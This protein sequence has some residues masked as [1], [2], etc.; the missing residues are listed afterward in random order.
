MADVS[1]QAEDLGRRANDNKW[2]D[3]GIR[4]GMICY[5]VVYLLIAWLA[6]QLA[7]GSQQSNASS[8]GALQLLGQ[9]S[10][11][12]LLLWLVAI[13]L[14]VLVIWRA[15]EALVGHQEYDGGKRT[16]RRL[17][18]AGKA[19]IY[20]YVAYLA[21]RYAIGAGSSG[22][23]DSTTAKLMDQPFGRFLVGLVGVAIAAYGV[24]QIRRGW[25]E[26]FMENLDAR[27]SAGDAGKA[28]RLDRQG[29]LHRQGHRLHPRRRPVRG[30]GLHPS[31]EEVGQPRP[32]TAQPSR[33]PVRPGAA[34]RHRRGNRLLR[35]VLLRAC[36]PPVPVTGSA[37]FASTGPSLPDGWGSR[38]PDQDDVPVLVA[39]R[40][41]DRA[42]FTGERRVDEAAI[43]SEVVGPASWTRRQVVVTDADDRVRG[44][45]SVQDRAAGRT[46][47]GL[48]LDRDAPD[49]DAVAAGLYAWADHEGRAIAHLRGL[50][51]TR[52]DAS[53]FAADHRQ[54]GWLEDAGYACRRRWLHM[55]R[56]V[57]ATEMMPPLREGVT[58]RRV[59]RHENGVP[60]AS[61]LQ[62]VH[63][64]LEESFQ[65]HFNSYRE[66]FPEFVQRLRED[67]GHR[68]DHWWLAWV[69][70]VP[71]GAIICSV[72]AAD[73]TGAEGTYVDYIGVNRVARGRGV[74]KGLL[75][76]VLSDAAERGRD[77]VSLEV[78]ADS[79]TR[80]D[81]LYVSMGWATDYVTESWFRD[82]EAA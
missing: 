41:A 60:L 56:P 48:W 67:P 78:D 64:M 22:S 50:E 63:R 77:R 36:P 29:G 61:D 51:R 11:G 53:P 57:D 74:A 47:V 46:V 69:D 35:V 28:Y 45:I 54:R 26:K 7:L 68:W 40:L 5:G 9:Q 19:V 32:G 12:P 37:P 81:G 13:G 14:T 27:G 20:G 16:R 82:V 15:L 70:D 55:S 80:A 25:T 73:R 49:E 30:G 24:A 33:L 75:H 6:L 79:P 18:S 42:P 52:M 38:L 39:L 44:W 43:E 21:F 65:D 58:V 23:T 10:F 4:F 59:A 71:A 34:D 1:D 2:M 8:K 31:R 66:S 72:L 62:I 76:T 17:M 3:R